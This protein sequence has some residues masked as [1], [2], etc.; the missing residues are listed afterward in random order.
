MWAEDLPVEQTQQL[1]R[2]LTIVE[3]LERVFVSG[4]RQDCCRHRRS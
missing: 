1:S 4:A 3:A 2:A